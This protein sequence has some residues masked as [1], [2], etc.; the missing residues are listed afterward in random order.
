LALRLLDLPP[1]DRKSDSYRAADTL[2]ALRNMLMQYK[3]VS[4]ER[5]N[6]SLNKS[7][8]TSRRSCG[9]TFPTAD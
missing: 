7:W 1:L 8:A 5:A 4:R 6:R 2:F 9:I 3:L